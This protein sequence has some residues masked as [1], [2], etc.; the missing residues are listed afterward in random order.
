MLFMVSEEEKQT[1]LDFL[2]REL[3]RFLAY[4]FKPTYSLYWQKWL[5]GP[6]GKDWHL[7][8]LGPGKFAAVSTLREFVVKHDI[9]ELELADIDHVVG[10]SYSFKKNRYEITFSSYE[11]GKGRAWSALRNIRKEYWKY[12]YK[13]LHPSN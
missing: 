8:F 13:L 9:S 2:T 3:N 1:I 7:F 5:K 6:D 11:I 12:R 4:E 10:F